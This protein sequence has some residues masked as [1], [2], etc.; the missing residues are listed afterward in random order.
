[1]A[2]RPAVLITLLVALSFLL[3]PSCR[4]APRTSLAEFHAKSQAAVTHQNLGSAI[5]RFW[6][7]SVP[8]C[9]QYFQFTSPP[10]R[11]AA[12]KTGSLC[13]EQLASLRGCRYHASASVLSLQPGSVWSRIGDPQ[14]DPKS[15]SKQKQKDDPTQSSGHQSCHYKGNTVVL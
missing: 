9:E 2:C 14:K 10:Q 1:M 3:L 8:L 4:Q 11:P 12:A 6:S 13:S 7:G 5:Y 15:D